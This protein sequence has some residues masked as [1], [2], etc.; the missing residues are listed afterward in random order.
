M[1]RDAWGVYTR[2]ALT[3]DQLERELPLDRPSAYA[4]NQGPA[5]EAVA[6]QLVAIF[7]YSYEEAL[8]FSTYWAGWFLAL[9]R[10]MGFGDST[11]TPDQS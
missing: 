8:T 5:S 1:S 4:L 11:T 6:A 3:V 9:Y 7:G 2:P 10:E